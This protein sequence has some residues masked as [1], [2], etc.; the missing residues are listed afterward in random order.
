MATKSPCT[1]SSTLIHQLERLNQL[2]N[3][4]HQFHSKH[5]ITCPILQKRIIELGSE[6][7]QFL[8]NDETTIA[9]VSEIEPGLL[10][11]I[12]NNM[13]LEPITTITLHMM[14]HK[15]LR[16]LFIAAGVIDKLK[17]MF[18]N[19][20]MS[21]NT[22]TNIFNI[23]CPMLDSEL[24]NGYQQE[25]LSLIQYQIYLN[26]DD[27]IENTLR[28][29]FYILEHKSWAKIDL[30]QPNTKQQL[31]FQQKQKINNIIFNNKFKEYE[32]ECKLELNVPIVLKELTRKFY[33]G[34]A[35]D[36]T[37]FILVHRLIDFIDDTYPVEIQIWSL[38]C[39]HYLGYD[40][41]DETLFREMNS[42]GFAKTIKA[43]LTCNT[44]YDLREDA[45]FSIVE[46]VY[47]FDDPEATEIWNIILKI[48]KD[49]DNDIS[50]STEALNLFFK[51]FGPVGLEVEHIEIML[52]S[53]L[54][55]IKQ[56]FEMESSSI[57]W[58]DV[59]EGMEYVI[60]EWKPEWK[61]EMKNLCRDIFRNYDESKVTVYDQ[62]GM[63]ELLHL[64]A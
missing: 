38:N 30:F 17:E 60:T 62:K 58:M 9:N 2:C 11:W 18:A 14:K 35:S 5:S 39:I 16:L 25:L 54:A 36:I 23:S 15:K 3:D 19:Y 42:Y 31:I 7:V 20:M 45:M 8:D 46:L 49:Y 28:F 12:I 55:I 41:I 52:K 43:L 21:E 63:E 33:D 61:P 1:F 29:F 47:R 48:A 53:L 26:D 10:K 24:L 27:I 40:N 4:Q 56:N 59:K 37:D 44:A 13:H 64:L 6:I 50:T 51:R 34:Y 22:L 57:E 32:K